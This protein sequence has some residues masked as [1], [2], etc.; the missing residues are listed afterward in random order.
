MKKSHCSAQG[1]LPTLDLMGPGDK[2]GVG[3]GGQER[4]PSKTQGRAS[5]QL[6]EELGG[7]GSLVK[8]FVSLIYHCPPTIPEPNKMPGM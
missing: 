3:E 8:A 7:T 6:W 5:H 2:L 4:T 1:S